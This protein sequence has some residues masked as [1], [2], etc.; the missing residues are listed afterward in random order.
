M[1]VTL[2]AAVSANNVIGKDGG[3]PWRLL[4]DMKHFKELTLGKVVV[5]GRKTYESI[6]ARFR[7]LPERVNVVL[8]RQ[9]DYNPEGCVVLHNVGEVLAKFPL[10]KHDLMIAGGSSV[11]KAFLP[12]ANFMELTRV[13]FE[14]EG[15]TF[16]PDFDE[17]AWKEDV[18]EEWR[19][20]A[21]VYG[22][23][24][25]IRELIPGPM[26]QFVRLTRA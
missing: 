24:E 25:H 14:V 3:I 16:F 13:G 11:Y 6:P 8:T 15:D 12:Y 9:R 20:V 1:P 10:N 19:K 26:H 21:P 22:T 7:P 5:M 23:P 4:K 18:Y 17:N 2:I